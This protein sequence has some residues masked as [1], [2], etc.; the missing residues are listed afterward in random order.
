MASL[1]VIYNFFLKIINNNYSSKEVGAFIFS[2][3]PG[4]AMETA[5]APA[6]APGFSSK[7]HIL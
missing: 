4:G 3:M 5:V 1:V 6:F 7:A 2:A